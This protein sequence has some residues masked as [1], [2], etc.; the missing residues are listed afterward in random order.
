MSRVASDARAR[1]VVVTGAESTGK[2]TL[3]LALSQSLGVSL[4]LEYARAYAERVQRELTPADVEPI[5][6]GQRALEDA[7][8][9]HADGGI[10]VL[11]TD[12]L[13]TLLYTRHYYGDAHVPSWLPKVIALRT[14]ALYLLCDT[15]IPWTPDP[16]RD[17][18]EAREAQQRT[19]VASVE[20]S[21]AMVVRVRGEESVRL[22]TARAAVR[23]LGAR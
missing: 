9:A 3:A 22:A 21:G 5:A 11:D 17:S 19:F 20:G 4:G 18:A 12:L 16:V 15:D 6:L 14:P 10:V 1:V 2:S 23:M 13:S 8:I 7:A